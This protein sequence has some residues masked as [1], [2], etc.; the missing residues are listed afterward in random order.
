[1]ARRGLLIQNKNANLQP[2]NFLTLPFNYSSMYYE[3]LL[4]NYWTNLNTKSSIHPLTFSTNVSYVLVIL[5][6]EFTECKTHTHTRLYL[7][8][9]SSRQAI[10]PFLQMR[11]LRIREVKCFS[12]L[13]SDKSWNSRCR[14]VALCHFTLPPPTCLAWCYMQGETPAPPWSHPR[15]SGM[16]G[17]SKIR[18]NS[19]N[20]T[21][22]RNTWNP[23]GYGLAQPEKIYR[24]KRHPS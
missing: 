16:G 14:A 20:S 17:Q 2:S 15:S 7:C 3:I 1:M 19:T 6:I 23:V 10:S 13:V 21:K 24:V 8:I 11:K 18:Q 4:K 22:I 9:S 12:Q 5:Q